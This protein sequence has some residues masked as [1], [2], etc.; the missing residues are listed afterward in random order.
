[1]DLQRK[2]FSNRYER[3]TVLAKLRQNG[4]SNIGCQDKNFDECMVKYYENDSK[5]YEFNIKL[6]FENNDLTTAIGQF[7]WI[8]NAKNK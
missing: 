3:K 8:R 2:F 4:Y 5:T 6:G 1:M 7:T